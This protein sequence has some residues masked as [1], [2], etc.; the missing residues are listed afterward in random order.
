VES[1][2]GFGNFGTYGGGGLALSG[3][4]KG[5]GGDADLLGGLGNKG[6][7]GGRV[8]TGRGATGTGN[9]IIGG[10]ARMTAI[11]VG[12]AEESIVMGAID[13]DAVLAAILAH[14]DEFRL[15]YEREVNAENPKLAGTVLTSF[16]I[17]SSGRVTQAGIESTSLKNANTERC[18]ITVLKRIDFPMPRGGGIVETKFPFKFSAVGK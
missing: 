4:G 5:G 18:V 11:R 8:G 7:G 3:S 9:G 15:C 10:Q 17:G 6:T 12:G 1:L 13:K 16:V 14:K 2:K